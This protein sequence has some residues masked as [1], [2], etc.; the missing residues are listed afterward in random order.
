LRV[1][2]RTAYKSH[3]NTYI[4]FCSSISKDPSSSLTEIELCYAAAN[5]CTSHKHTSLPTYIAA[6]SHYHIAAGHGVLPRSHLYMKV[7]Q[8]IK[9]FYGLIEQ[10]QPKQA[11]TVQDLVT[12]H[13][14]I[15]F[16]LFNDS[17]DWCAYIFSFFGLLRLSEIGSR[18]QCQHITVHT[19][20]V[21]ITV[22]YS[23]T[24]L[25][26]VTIRLCKRDDI[27]CPVRA[28]YSYIN[29][30]PSRLQLPSMPFFRSSASTS[31]SVASQSMRSSLQQR[32]FSLF[33]SDRDSIGW[34][35]FRRGG[36]TALFLAGVSD[37]LIAAHGRWKSFTYRKYFDTN[38]HHILPTY[39]LM[40]HTKLQ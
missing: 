19:W 20:G 5:F 1:R 40:L 31:A 14:S 24:N 23:K 4:K 18:L 30:L 35:S 26:P 8:G 10:Q 38:L 6:L 28:Y 2:S 7:T 21:A 29:W 9:N 12:I 36:A 25:R 32:C 37:S 33:N 17:R 27:L 22:Q 13:A 3:Y 34:H 15:N 39:R 16:S 11:L